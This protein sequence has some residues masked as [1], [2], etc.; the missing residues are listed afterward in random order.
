MHIFKNPITQKRLRRFKQR[1]R[2]WYSLWALVGLYV[3][4]LGAELICNEKPLMVRYNGSLYFPVFKYYPED[5]FLNNGIQSRPDYLRLHHLPRF[6][7]DGNWMLFPLIKYGPQTNIDPASLKDEEIVTVR[8]SPV[9]HVGSLDINPDWQVIRHRKADYFFSDKTRLNTETPVTAEWI[10]PQAFQEAVNKRFENQ[11]A[12][13]LSVTLTNQSNP[14]LL[15]SWALSTYQPR[16][17]APKKIRITL[18]QPLDESDDV[19]LLTFTPDMTIKGSYPTLWESLDNTTRSTILQQAEQR[20]SMP[21]QKMNIA[22][23]DTRYDVTFDK[24]DVNWPF[25]PCRGHWLGIDSSG[26]DVLARLIYGLRISMSFGLVLALSAMFFGTIVGSIQ[27]Y[28]GGYIDIIVQRIIEIW[29]TLPFLYMMILLGSIFMRSFL[30]LLIGYGIFNW[31]G[32]SYYMRAEF[33]KLRNYPFV[34]AAR[35]MGIPSRKIIF[36]HILPN[37]LTPLITFFPFSLIGAIGS[38]AAL[39]YLG[40]G[41]PPPTPSWGEMLHQAQEFR[42]AWWLILYPSLALFVVIILSAFTGEGV[43]DAFD[44]RPYSRMK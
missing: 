20:F 19:S 10:I 37:A 30:L 22:I 33:L 29:A 12:D 31:I 41:L 2:A 8:F 15:A 4:S 7:E 39:D 28:Y 21:I 35:C 34:D 44:P 18:R 40:F 36:K 3:L 6:N 27:G 17:S 42:W 26:R 14:F 9:P 11:A 16:S 23:G 43:R 5:T 13:A 25:P 24:K 38:L 1:R 32:I